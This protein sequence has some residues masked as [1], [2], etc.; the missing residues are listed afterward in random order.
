[1][2]I[3]AGADH[4][5]ERRTKTVLAVILLLAIA[6]IY[7]GICGMR[8]LKQSGYDDAKGFW[9]I[10]DAGRLAGRNSDKDVALLL[11]LPA[12]TQQAVEAVL[13]TTIRALWQRVRFA[14]ETAQDFA[15]ADGLKRQSVMQS[16][17]LETQ[18]ADL[19]QSIRH[20]AEAL[21]LIREGMTTDGTPAF[22]KLMHDVVSL[23]PASEAQPLRE[24]LADLM[25][26]ESAAVQ[27]DI[28]QRSRALFEEAVAERRLSR[29]TKGGAGLIPVA[30]ELFNELHSAAPTADISS[31]FDLVKQVPRQQEAYASLFVLPAH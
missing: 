15:R 3:L 23:L 1:M 9:L 2:R 6:M 20:A 14:G 16:L 31:A 21:S 12:D 25:R 22:E 17:L 8:T 27:T 4:T 10:Y 7:L 24:R 28:R 18:D 5:I 29:F 11:S 26:T 13:D 30:R 19:Q